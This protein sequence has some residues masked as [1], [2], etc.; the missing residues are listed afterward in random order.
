MA[1]RIHPNAATDADAVQW[2]RG[3]LA[4]GYDVGSWI[5]D[6]FPRY[7]R[8]LHPAHEWLGADD[9]I[10]ER[11]VSW[12]EIASWSGKALTS[13]SVVDDIVVRADGTSWNRHGRSL[14][15]EGQLVQPH[16]DRLTRCLTAATSTPDTVWLLV[17][18][19]YG[20]R[21]EP[22]LLVRTRRRQRTVGALRRRFA[23]R[24]WVPDPDRDLGI[25]ISPA[26]TGSGRTY[27][28]HRGAIDA[29]PNGE[30]PGAPGL[31]PSFWW[32]ADRAWFVSTEIDI[33]STYVGGSTSLI[34]A[35]LADDLLEALPAD[36]GDRLG[37]APPESP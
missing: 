7:A 3:H 37:G 20:G 6:G 33:S 23:R 21:G 27:V 32:P 28:L 12:A 17:W 25:E 4:F 1:L 24:R 5:P 16:L 19:G 30:D 11:F 18:S 9:R 13:R 34:E 26:L 29:S 35:L 36:L 31:A 2:L 8:I 14:P 10:E 22:E 15:M